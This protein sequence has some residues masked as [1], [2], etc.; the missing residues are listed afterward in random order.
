L[1]DAGGSRPHPQN[2]AR[3]LPAQPALGMEIIKS[4]AIEFAWVSR[5]NMRAAG[6]LDIR[7]M[8]EKPFGTEF[9]LIARST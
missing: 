2:E 1:K 7:N 5:S 8:F 6:L 3:R 4:Y 9:L